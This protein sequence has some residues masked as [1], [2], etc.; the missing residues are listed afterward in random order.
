MRHRETDSP[1]WR[2]SWPSCSWGVLAGVAG[3]FLITGVKGFVL[4][5]QNAVLAQ[6][7]NLALARMTRELTVE[8][9]E[10][11]SLTTAGSDVVGVSFEN[12]SGTRRNLLLT[13]GGARKSLML[14]TGSTPP[15]L[16]QQ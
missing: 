3:L 4:S 12:A 14:N 16:L 8:L 7:A 9:E 6:K 5:R 2:S 15:T 1:S 11:A 10:V 13:G